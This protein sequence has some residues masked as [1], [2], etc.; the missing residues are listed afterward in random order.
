LNILELTKQQARLVQL[1]AQGLLT[2]PAQP[3]TRE[4]VLASIRR[5]GLLQIDTI[6]VVAR[7][8]YFV[9]F[10][11][12]GD[13]NSRWLDEFL[14]DKA[15]FEQWAHAACF[16][17]ME[18]FPLSRR[19]VLDKLRLSDF[20]DWGESN[21]ELINQVLETVRMNGAMRSADFV[22]KKEPGGWWNWK[23][24][25]T[26]L[27][28]WLW[29]GELMVARRENFQRV[30][31]LTERLLPDWN[32]DDVPPLNEVYQQMIRSTVCAL[33]VARPSWVADY[34]RLKKKVI[35]PLL[36][37]MLNSG[38]LSQVSIEGWDE[39]A[40]FV[41]ENETLLLSAASGELTTDH[42]TLLS[43]FDPLTWDRE[44][45]RQ[46]FNFDFVIQCY[47]PAAK[48]QY[49][50]FP[51][52]ILHHGELVGR[53]DAKAHR[54][55]RVFEVKTLYLEDWVIPTNELALS[56]GQAIQRCAD[57]HQTPR[58]ILGEC[59]PVEFKSSLQ[60]VVTEKPDDSVS[61]GSS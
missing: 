29:K 9:L 23:N 26:A 44:R 33:G 21:L 5:M 51:L 39:P 35:P 59:L 30:Y 2:P 14:V 13:Y 61:A 46:L 3:A 32:D 58:V 18:D 41:L 34:Y 49:G 43:P 6:H 22:S 52:P 20:A 60:T 7:S 48:R 27:E 57:W 28:Y 53:L 25:K 24:E 50:Y 37:M 19:L 17:P 45:A 12:L 40:L 1:A 55:E 16:I 42:T 47:T 10:S 36:E 54:K 31:D 11:R 4:D 15:L 38:D 8:P 56:L